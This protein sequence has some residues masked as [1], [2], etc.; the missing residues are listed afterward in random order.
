MGKMEVKNEKRDRLLFLILGIRPYLREF[1][2]DESAGKYLFPM[3]RPDLRENLLP[4]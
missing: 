1:Y 4:Y 2:R 3:A